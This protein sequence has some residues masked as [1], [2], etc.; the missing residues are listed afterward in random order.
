MEVNL[1]H[2]YQCYVALIYVVFPNNITLIRMFCFHNTGR[3]TSELV[4]DN[5]HV[6]DNEDVFVVEDDPLEVSDYIS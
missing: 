2:I 6:I 4:I 5:E 3:S 1:L